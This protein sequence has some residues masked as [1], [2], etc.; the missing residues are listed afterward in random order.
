MVLSYPAF[1]TIY[2]VSIVVAFFLG[3]LVLMGWKEMSIRRALLSLR[4]NAVYIIILVAFP[5]LLV[6]SQNMAANAISDPGDTSKEVHY[7]NWIFSIAGDAVAI[8]Q[9]RLHHAIVTDFFAIT[10]VWLFTFLTGFVPILLLAKDDR[11]TLRTYAIATVL[12]YLV[13]APFYIFFPVTVT[14]S[15]IAAQTTPLLYADPIWGR[16]VTNVDPLNNDFPSAHVSLSTTTFLVFVYA[17]SRYKRFSYFLGV[18]TIAVVLA[19]LYLGVHWPADVFAGFLV[20]VGATVAA[21]SGRV[22]MTIDRY[23]RIISRRLLNEKEPPD[24]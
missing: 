6:L 23:V 13:L 8:I 11:A 22:Q 17:G 9:D 4:Y 1:F 12:N 15:N 14:G 18:S 2:F 3:V 20:A 7:T 21:R 24:D 16:M 5:L 19:V 10:Y